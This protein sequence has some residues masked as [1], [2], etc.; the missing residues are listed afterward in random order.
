MNLADVIR[1]KNKPI[2][3]TIKQLHFVSLEEP[4]QV[5]QNDVVLGA[6]IRATTSFSL[7]QLN[8]MA[9]LIM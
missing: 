9:S 7:I 5:I 4:S 3:K 8:A 2:L 6:L 1:G